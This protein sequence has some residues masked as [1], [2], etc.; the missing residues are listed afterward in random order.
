[1][2]WKNCASCADRITCAEHLGLVETTCDDAAGTKGEFKLS[3]KY[4]SHGNI[5][6]HL[7][8]SILTWKIAINFS[9]WIVMFPN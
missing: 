3:S 5:I 1:M 7:K 2:V 9:K 8:I 4:N 6:S